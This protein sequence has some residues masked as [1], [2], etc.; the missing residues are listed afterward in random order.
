[1]S[2]LKFS[3]NQKLQTALQFT[4]LGLCLVGPF[5]MPAKQANTGFLALS[6]SLLSEDHMNSHSLVKGKR[7]PRAYFR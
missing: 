2:L 7:H 3:A 4:Y 6:K 1:M 5:M